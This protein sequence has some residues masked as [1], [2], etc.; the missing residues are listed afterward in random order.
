MSHA[1]RRDFLRTTSAAASLATLNLAGD[2]IHAAEEA[3]LPLKILFFGGDLREVH[4]DL[5]ATYRLEVRRGGQIDNKQQDDNVQGLEHLREV[6][7]WVG[8]ANKRTF[9]SEEQLNY[10]KEYLA[11]GKPFVGYRAASH[12]FQNWLEV[13]KQVFGAKYG[14]HHLLNKDPELIV[15][16]AEGAL[17]H[18][19]FRG[20]T[21]PRPASG[22]Y[23]YTE[24][25]PDVKVLLYSG[26]GED[27]MPHTWVREI[28][29]TGNRAFYTRY[30]SAQIA[31]EPVVRE[32]FL[33][34]ILWALNRDM[35]VYAKASGE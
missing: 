13:D 10:F 4:A 33:R 27:M 14:G 34:G 28:K 8:S 6:D 18:A 1:S 24:L 19:I 11:A 25:E 12:V 26:L 16:P 35:S 3:S 22:S 2:A 31:R 30:D 15:K 29:A 23:N 5:E 9:P 21:P 32:I 20:I 7:L 17:E